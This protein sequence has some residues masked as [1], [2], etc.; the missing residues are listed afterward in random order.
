MSVLRISFYQEG[1]GGTELPILQYIENDR[2]ISL[3]TDSEFLYEYQKAVLSALVESGTLSE[4]QFRFA[5]KKLRKQ[6]NEQE[7]NISAHSSK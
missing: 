7:K 5:D 2:E 3:R 4:A 1:G 6:R